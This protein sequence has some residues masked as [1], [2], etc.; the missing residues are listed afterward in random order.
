MS[1]LKTLSSKYC[2]FIVLLSNNE[3][4]PGLQPLYTF[5]IFLL[6]NTKEKLSKVLRFGS[7]PKAHL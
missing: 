5:S 3:K 1:V 7:Q 4:T 6:F 2:L